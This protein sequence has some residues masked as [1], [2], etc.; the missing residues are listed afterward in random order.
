MVLVVA[1][2]SLVVAAGVAAAPVAFSRELPSEL[3]W[4][5]LLTPLIALVL[6]GRGIAQGTGKV[7]HTQLPTELVRPGIM[8]AVLV[9]MWVLARPV[10]PAVA[11]A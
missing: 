11:I 10:S 5:L 6:L 7:V 3:V 1:P 4:A 8:V 9:A 2:A